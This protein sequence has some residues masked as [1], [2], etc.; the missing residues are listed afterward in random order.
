MVHLEV[1]MRKDFQSR[2]ITWILVPEVR[3]QE[4]PILE[5]HVEYREMVHDKVMYD[6]D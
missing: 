4:G 3:G 5:I 6:R 1:D 2:S